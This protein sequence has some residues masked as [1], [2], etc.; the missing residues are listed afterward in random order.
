MK[1]NNFHFTHSV[2]DINILAIVVSA[3]AAMVLGFVWYSMPV[4]GRAWTRLTGMTAEK[5]EQAKTAGMTK[6]YVLS[7]I[8]ALVMASVLSYAVDIAGA[9]TLLGGM[10]IGALAWLGFSA[11]VA[12]NTVL[13]GDNKWGV[14]FI[15][16]GYQ[17]VS[18]IIMGAILAVW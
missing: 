6:T 17:L 16:T 9:A 11:P 7:F 5:M 4:F 15:E 8:G 10:G 14:Y 3:I 12:M 13:F 1:T 18:L 2:S